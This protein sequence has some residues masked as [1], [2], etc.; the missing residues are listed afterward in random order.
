MKRRNHQPVIDS[1]SND[2]NNGRGHGANA[3]YRSAPHVKGGGGGSTGAPTSGREGLQRT[4]A[5]VFD[6]LDAISESKRK[7]SNSL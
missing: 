4:P 3:P 1:D 7:V 5:E 2:D 6:L